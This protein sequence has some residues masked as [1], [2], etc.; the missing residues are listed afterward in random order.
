V[1][2]F[3]LGFDGLDDLDGFVGVVVVERVGAADDVTVADGD[4]CASGFESD[5]EQPASS[6]DA[7]ST[8]STRF[9]AAAGRWPT[10]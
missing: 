1:S 3:G 10:A 5:D 2:S 6:N 4:R 9:R 7:A 8:A